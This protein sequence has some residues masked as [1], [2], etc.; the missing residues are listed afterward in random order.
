MR[1]RYKYNGPVCEFKCSKPDAY[2]M[3]LAAKVIR[4]TKAFVVNAAITHIGEREFARSEF[5]S[6]G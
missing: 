6:R 4:V 3:Q 2:N 5:P 1:G